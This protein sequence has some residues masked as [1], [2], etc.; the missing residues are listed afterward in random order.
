MAE[1]PT[2]PITELAATAIQ[3]HEL[4]ES[5]LQ[6]GFTTDQAFAVV[7]TIIGAATAHGLQNPTPPEA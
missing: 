5:Y 2:D 6:A 7:L 4:Y 3:M 1:L